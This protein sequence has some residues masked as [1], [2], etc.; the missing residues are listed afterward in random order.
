MLVCE[1]SACDADRMPSRVLE[2][3]RDRLLASLDAGDTADEQLAR[4]WI[5]AQELRL[6][7]QAADRHRAAQLLYRW[8]AYCADTKIPEPTRLART[9]DFWPALTP[10]KIFTSL[11]RVS[12]LPARFA[13]VALP[14]VSL[15]AGGSTR[16]L[17]LIEPRPALVARSRW[18]CGA[19]RPWGFE[20]RGGL[21]TL[22]HAVALV[23]DLL[24]DR[25]S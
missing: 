12:S 24:L 7:Y 5:A 16:R 8:L 22:P 15:A 10:S 4:T 1:L 20:S 2:P 18:A 21:E 19:R 11:V 9:I 23:E 17:Y 6:I 13:D 3:D 14:L 25:P